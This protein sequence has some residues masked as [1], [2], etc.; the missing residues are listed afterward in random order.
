[1]KLIVA[2]PSLDL[3][4]PFSATPAW[5]QLLKGLDECGVEL[6]VTAYH[7]RVPTAPWW[8][9][10]PN[11]A[12]LEGQIFRA[13]RSAARRALRQSTREARFAST[14]DTLSQRMTRQIARR[15][16]APKWHRHLTR[17][18]KAEQDV[19]AVILLSIPPNH[20]R[21]VPAAIR[22]RFDIPVVLYDGDVPASLP[23]HGGFAS[24]FDIYRGADLGEY[25]YVISNSLGGAQALLDLGAVE[26]HT[27]YYAAD[28]S[29]YEPLTLHQDIDVFF[30]GHTTEY[31]QEWMK[32]MLTDAAERIPEAHFAA[33]GLGLGPLGEVELL[34]YRTFS[35]LRRYIARSKL[36]LVIVRQPHASLYGSSILRPFELAMMGACMVCN[37]WLGVEEWFEPDKELIIVNSAEEAVDR[38]RFYLAH[39]YERRAI[40]LAA[41]ERAL[42]EHTYRQRA[43]EMVQ[44][45]KSYR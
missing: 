26:V 40:G 36:N 24:G 13:L 14:G 15:V 32:A 8:R 21:G 16:I 3:S 34:P 25:A 29:L 28:P 30:Y 23:A 1:M 7:G 45:L 39:E 20:L 9:A 18:L 43:D 44:M 19:D 4:V 5:W 42:S 11:P 10:Y 37:P 38:Y 41:R 31:R 17:M 33:R 2:C 6:A 12:R 35:A 27:L 22:Q